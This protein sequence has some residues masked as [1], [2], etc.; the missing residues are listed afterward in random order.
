MS[1]IG[2]QNTEPVLCVVDSALPVA[3]AGLYVVFLA[4]PTGAVKA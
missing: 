2:C 3:G 4:R 1:G